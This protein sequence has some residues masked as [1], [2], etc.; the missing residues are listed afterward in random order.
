[1]FRIDSVVLVSA[2]DLMI[3]KKNNYKKLYT[4]LSSLGVLPF[5]QVVFKFVSGVLFLVLSCLLGN[6]C[7]LTVC[8]VGVDWCVLLSYVYLWYYMCIFFLL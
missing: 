3:V 5:V 6:C 2:T 4:V 7:W 1:V 8:I